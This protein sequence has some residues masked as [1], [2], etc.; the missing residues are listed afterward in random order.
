MRICFWVII[1]SILFLIC[2]S[3]LLML[4][5]YWRQMKS[6]CRQLRV[7]RTEDSST[8]IWLD[9]V[10]G[11]FRELQK[12]LNLNIKKQREER[13]EHREQEQAFKEF[14]SNVSH[15]I[16][17]PIT[18]VSGYFQLFLN[19][20]DETKRGE[21]ANIITERIKGFQTMLE[22]FYDYSTAVSKDR[23]IENDKCDIIR[24]ASECLF[25]YYKEIE[26]TLGEPMLLFPEKEICAFA[27][28][29]EL[30]RVIQNV[31]SNAIQH[32]CGD[33]KVSIEENQRVQLR[34]ENRTKEFLS[35]NPQKVFERTYK[36]DAARTRGG[37]GL[38]L[39][40][41]KELVERMGGTVVAYAPEN[42]RFGIL[43]ELQKFPG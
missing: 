33:F 30:R 12:E 13:K 4:V 8:D 16:R 24:L 29:K 25:L 2:L 3:L 38:G 37:S 41:V 35:E 7:H 5:L 1:I 15:D 27:S 34:F 39:S 31:I 42:G 20:K 11:P 18:S 14:V 9:I 6:I 40:I 21:Y 32:G 43:I 36:A 23:E 17:T 28:D 22:D 10:N 19:T 26:E